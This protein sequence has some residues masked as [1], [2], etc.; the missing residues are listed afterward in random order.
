M[1]N[2]KSLQERWDKDILTDNSQFENCKQC[3]GC[4]FQNDGDI[5][6]NH[7]TK[8]SCQKYPYPKFKPVEIIDN[9]IECCFRELTANLQETRSSGINEL[10][11]IR[12]NKNMEAFSEKSL[13]ALGDCYVYGLVDPRTDKLFYI[14][15]GTSNRVFEHEKESLSSPKSDK[16][17]LK[18]IN[19]I[20]AAGLEVK[21]II[22]NSNLSE[23][24]AFAAEASLINIFNYISD[25][26]LTN[27]V[28]G[29]HSSGVL[30]VE[31]FERIN[32]A[33]ELKKEDI[34]HNIVFIKIN[35]MYRRDMS[36]DELYDIIRGVWV[37]D[38]N[39]ISSAEYV[40]GLYN[41]LIVA[42]FKPTK[43]FKCK[44]AVERLPK[45]IRTLTKEL[46][47]RIFFV[48]EA[49]EN[50][51]PYDENQIFYCW[52]S[53]AELEKVQKSQNPIIY[54]NC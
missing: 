45:R 2:R 26:M 35:K 11:N 49:F 48:D 24:E 31:E 34:R 5:W 25:M 47:D 20:V 14:G 38:K 15:K 23:K 37:A 54:I 13:I 41:S 9:E 10:N 46:G 39:R 22:I 53:V 6:S 16:L 27:I 42:V 43:W 36:A 8:S 7:Y 4:R 17:K 19:E 32:G 50:G 44:E 18:T 30:T 51:S 21:K 12:E 28:A 52:K 3:K 40:L 1:E 33:D 29:H